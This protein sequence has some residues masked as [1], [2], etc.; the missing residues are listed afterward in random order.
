MKHPNWKKAK[1]KKKRRRSDPLPPRPEPAIPEDKGCL[2]SPYSDEEGEAKGMA[3][4]VVTFDEALRRPPYHDVL[5]DI[6]RLVRSRNKEGR[7]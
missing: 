2:R 6:D 5:K 7:A 4:A 1:K 3:R